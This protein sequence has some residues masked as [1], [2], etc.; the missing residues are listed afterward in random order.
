MNWDTLIFDLQTE[1]RMR[2]ESCAYLSDILI[3]QDNHGVTE[4]MVEQALGVFRPSSGKK[5]GACLIVMKPAGTKSESDSP[6]FDLTVRLNVQ[7]MTRPLIN[8]ATAGGGSGKQAET[9]KA[10]VMTELHDYFSGALKLGLHMADKPWSP[11]DDT[12]EGVVSYMVHFETHTAFGGRS[13]VATP[14]V[15]LSG[16]TLTLTC[17][18]AGATIYYT[19][20]GTYPGS[21][22]PT[23]IEYTTPFTVADGAVLRAGAVKADF[24]PSDTM[25]ANI[26]AVALDL[27]DGSLADTGLG[28]VIGTGEL[29]VE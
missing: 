10:W 5:A 3:C 4:S 19:T 1:L 16:T 11:V 18:T 14:D 28:A 26:Q 29:S 17:A 20:D 15:S 6:L 7:V 8:D 21:A 2:L 24:I 23:S 9:L 13:S 22:N 12:A 25:L 27:G